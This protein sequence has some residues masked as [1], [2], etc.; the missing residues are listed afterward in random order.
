M[1]IFS[2]R[3]VA[4]LFLILLDFVAIS[5]KAGA[6]TVNGTLLGTVKDE[7]GAVVPNAPV[8]ARNTE[9]GAV[10]STTTDARGSFQ[11]SSVPAG[12][13]EITAN[14]PG[15][16][17]EVRNKI[18]VTVGADTRVDFVLS[19]GGVEEKVE[20]T[21]EAPQIDTT[22]SAMGGL[23][24]DT[25]VRELPLNGRDWLQLAELQP[26]ATFFRGQSQSDVARLPRGN[27]QAIS[28]SGGRPAENVFRLDGLVINDFA[29][30]SPGSALWVNMGVDA[31]REFSVLT[32]T[33]S[34]EYGRSSGGVINAITKSGTNDIHGTAFYFTRNSALDAR[35]FFD[36]PNIPPFR[37]H[38]FGGSIG[39]PIKKDKTFYFVNYEGLRE[40][41]SLSFQSLTLSANARNGNLCANAACSS[42][43]TVA[44]DPRVRPYLPLYPIPNLSTS[45][46]TGIFAFGGGRDGSENFVIGR[47][48]H[49]FSENTM[50]NATYRFDYSQV[51][52]PDGFDE[53]LTAAKTHGQN[54]I[55]SLQHIFS[56]TVLNT[57]RAGV[58]RTWATDG[59]DISPASP[60]L[61]DTSLG[62][63]P[64]IPTGDFSV[65]GLQGFGGI[66]DTGSDVVGYT[67]PQFYDDLS[68]TKGRHSL[69]FGFGVERIDDNVNPQT[70]PNGS[71]VFGSIQSMLTASPASFTAAVPGTDTRRGFRTSIFAG[72]IQDDFRYRSN[73]TFN[74]GLRYETSTSLKEVNGKLGN[75][76]NITDPAPTVGN[77]LF[78]NPTL[79][80]F[81]PRIGLAWDP[82][83][84]G[85]TSVRAGFG[86][87]DVLPL[88]YL[89]WNKATHGLPFFEI[90][91]VNAPTNVSTA[92]LAS[93]F[94]NQG[95]SLVSAQSLRVLYLESHPHRPY[96][97]QWNFNIQRQIAKGL[98]LMAGYVGS[99]SSHLPVGQN[100]ADMVPPALTTKSPS[101]QYLFPTTGTIQRINPNFGRIDATFFNGHATYHAL[102]TNLAKTMSHGLTLQATYSWSKSLDNGSTTFSQSETLNSTDNG[103]IFD[104]KILRGVS[105]YDVPQTFALNLVW[106]VP[107]PASFTGASKALLSGW[108]LGGIFT[109]QSGSPF[110]VGLQGDQART[111]TS[112]SNAAGGERPNYVAGPGCSTNA[113][114]GNPNNYLNTACFAFPALG[115][116]GN[117]GR[118]TLRGPSLQQFDF[119]LFKNQPLW[120]EKLRMQFR[121]ETFN[122]LNHSNLQAQTTTLFNRTGA[123]ISTAG[124][125]APPTATSSRQIQFGMKFIW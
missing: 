120:G 65:A 28:I 89:F 27:G 38:Q 95:L 102:Q 44:I 93:A 121:V 113:V 107:T 41:K 108:Q 18:S 24:N 2:A 49:M 122:L 74:I 67:A 8:S 1:K 5:P 63:L 76:L 52:T 77:P 20:V 6:Q 117:L 60:L 87:Y 39:G 15:F 19:V 75:L 25:T 59:A 37:R 32:N 99:A 114:T 70:T 7:Q 109:A 12:A 83:K 80:D 9:T 124:L 55:V 125:L 118:N 81:E 105:D 13:Y 29:N 42:T 115:Q 79:K 69:K 85:K 110:T 111:G 112:T 31:V 3:T 51:S 17:T 88:P 22:T 116:L 123:L 103:Y 66:G 46:D 26:G 68:W 86:I 43:T 56:P 62:F 106:E 35:N 33:Y 54:F 30:Q 97:M 11:I 36:G 119:S 72:Y 84:D 73:L 48:D 98:T 4:I 96:K 92:A 53:K 47:V 14:A 40:F 61:T 101:G 34:A 90:G 91:V 94:P 57:V 104:Q 100:D 50:L 58:T 64:G 10:R 71:W 78:Q 82:F 21:G 16:K 45:G 23:V